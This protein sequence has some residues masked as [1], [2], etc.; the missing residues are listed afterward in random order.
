MKKCFCHFLIS[1]YLVLSSVL[2]ESSGLLYD[3]TYNTLTIIRT[4]NDSIIPYIYFKVLVFFIV[5][6]SYTEQR[7]YY[8]PYTV[9]QWKTHFRH[10]NN[11]GY[12][13]NS[14]YLYRNLN[15]FYLSQQAKFETP[16]Q[17]CH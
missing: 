7:E 2:D 16:F 9:K 5:Q 13:N 4:I 11:A 17:R 1:S 8:H 6:S 3:I 15:R 14:I 10:F 12:S